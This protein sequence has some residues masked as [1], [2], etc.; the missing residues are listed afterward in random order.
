MNRV[1]E[2]REP[3]PDPGRFIAKSDLSSGSFGSNYG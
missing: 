3:G 1:V 2:K